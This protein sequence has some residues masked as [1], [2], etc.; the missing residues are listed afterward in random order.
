MR[1]LGQR[2]G[3]ISFALVIVSIFL[4]TSTVSATIIGGTVTGGQANAQGGIFMKIAPGFTVSNPDN[5]VGNNTFQN[6]NLYGFDEDQNILLAAILNVN[7]GT[8]PM[9]G[10]TVASHYIFFDPNLATTITGTVDF[11]SDVIGIIT[12]TNL[13]SASDILANTGVNYLSPGLRGL[14][15]GDN[16]MISG[17]QQISISWRA[18]TPG[19][20]IRVLTQFS[21]AATIPEPGTIILFGSGLIGLAA[22]RRFKKNA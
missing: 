13:L 14:E 11:D 18:S 3:F 16:V 17:T 1:S 10:E 8:S 2:S 5:T 4:F 7:I 20:Y 9:A 6:P 15:G 12:S 21:P 19:D 22:W